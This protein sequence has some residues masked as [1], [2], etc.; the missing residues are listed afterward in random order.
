MDYGM[1]TPG[2][3]IEVTSKPLLCPGLI[4]APKSRTVG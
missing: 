3:S 1:Y 2:A 4:M